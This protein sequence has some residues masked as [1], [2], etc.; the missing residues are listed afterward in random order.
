MTQKW[1]SR[2]TL[3]RHAKSAYNDLKRIKLEDRTYQEFLDAYDAD[4]ESDL[5]R[6]LAMRCSQKWAMGVGDWNTQ[7]AEGSE[8]TAM[9]TGQ[10]LCKARNGKVPDIVFVSPYHRTHGTLAALINGWP[11]LGGCE[12][13]EDERIRE[14]EHGLLLLYNDLRVLFA[15]HPEQRKLYDL[16]GSY[17]YRY[18]QGENVP[19]VRQRNREFIAMLIREFSGADVLVVTH[20]LTILATRANLERLNSEEFQHLDREEKPINCGVTTYVGTPDVGRRGEGR[21]QL[22]SYNVQLF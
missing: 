10:G 3:I 14:Q 7:L 1:P 6:D 17:W 16:E 12:T 13:Y 5:T 9:A 18:P 4:W 11:E 19:D 8:L 15:L 21:I 2:L 22:E 20:H